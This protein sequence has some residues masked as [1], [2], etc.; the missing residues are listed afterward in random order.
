MNSYKINKGSYEIFTTVNYKIIITIKKQR[1]LTLLY[2][3]S[4]KKQINNDKQMGMQIHIT[5]KI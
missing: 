5:F 4:I 3:S 2:L 1:F